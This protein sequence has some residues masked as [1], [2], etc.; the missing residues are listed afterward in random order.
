VI[1][2]YLLDLP[3]WVFL[4]DLQ[5]ILMAII[6][7]KNINPDTNTERKHDRL[8]EI[9]KKTMLSK[10]IRKEYIYFKRG[11]FGNQILPMQKRSSK[12]GKL[13]FVT[14]EPKTWFSHYIPDVI[15]W[16]LQDSVVFECKVSRSDFIADGKKKNKV[17]VFFYYFVPAGIIK[18]DELRTEG[19]FEVPDDF[20][21]REI[22]L[23]EIRLIKPCVQLANYNNYQEEQN[24]L[25]YVL[26]H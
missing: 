7:R 14:T 3:A 10:S 20:D 11:N 19:L 18:P 22:K 13:W 4:I 24:C 9:A 6:Y 25:F 21:E 26:R 16:F 23:K 8:I 5:E 2:G 1:V 12:I 17:G 15:G